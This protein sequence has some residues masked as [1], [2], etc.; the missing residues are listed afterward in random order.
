MHDPTF[1]PKMPKQRK[2]VAKPSSTKPPQSSRNAAAPPTQITRFQDLEEKKP[3][4]TKPPQSSRNAAAPPTQITRFQDLEASLQLRIRR[5]LITC[6]VWFGLVVL[7][8][9]L[10]VMSK[11]YL[12]R[13]REERLRHGIKSKATPKPS[14]P[15]AQTIHKQSRNQ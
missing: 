10:F 6:G 3:S 1:D 4:S 2:S 15:Y 9:G 5:T 13:R 8:A 14:A 11:P 12:D 7:S